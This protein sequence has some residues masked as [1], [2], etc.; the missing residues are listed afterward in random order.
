MAHIKFMKLAR[1][2]DWG[3]EYVTYAPDRRHCRSLG[4]QADA[5]DLKD[6]QLVR[7]RFPDGSTATKAI[8]TRSYSTTVG[9]MGHVYPVSYDLPGVEVHVHGIEVWLPLDELEL[10]AGIPLVGKK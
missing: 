2:N 1:G 9:D 5:L 4:R 7:V 10:E 8:C 3:H 6:G